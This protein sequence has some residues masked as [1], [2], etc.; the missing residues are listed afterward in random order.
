MDIGLIGGLWMPPS[1]WDPVLGELEALGH[2]GVPV[3]LPGQGDGNDTATFEDQAA[4]VAAAVDA[5]DSPVVVGHSAAS[6][7]ACVA[8]DARPEAVSAVAFIGGWPVQ[9]GEKYA[10]FFPVT[11]GAMP[12]P[13]WEPFEGPDSADLDDDAKARLAAGA[14]PVPE[15]VARGVVRYGDGRR[16]RVR[17]AL[18]CPEFSPADAQEMLDGGNLPELARADRLSLVDL[19]SG[20]WPMVSAPTALAR[21]LAE[22]AKG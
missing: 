3:T 4:A 21:V 11:D 7:L 9:D 2:R 1:V 16:Y 15:G 6:T 12:F 5:A 10:D 17:A 13:G 18:I 20:H 22:V 8:A 14:I 19:D